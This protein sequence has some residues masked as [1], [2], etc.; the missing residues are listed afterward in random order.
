METDPCGLSDPSGHLV[1]VSIVLASNAPL[2][3][4]AGHARKTPLVPYLPANALQPS[5]EAVPGS[6]VD[7]GEQLAHVAEELAPSTSLYVPATQSAQVPDVVAPTTPL[8][9]PFLQAVNE[10]RLP[11]QPALAMHASISTLALGLVDPVGHSLQVD[12]TLTA[13]LKV[14]SLHAVKEP[15][16][17]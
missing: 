5:I 7:P 14:P 3:V 9:V 2:Y 10:P 17:A 15:L 4:P 8:Y 1:H 13:P 16:S 11:Y 12:S 6:L